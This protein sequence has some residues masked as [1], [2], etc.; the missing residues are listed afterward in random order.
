MT[1][2][3]Q[4]TAFERIRYIGE[5][6]QHS[7]D[8]MYLSR[9]IS[10]DDIHNGRHSGQFGKFMPNVALGNAECDLFDKGGRVLAQPCSQPRWSFRIHFSAPFPKLTSTC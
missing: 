1:S 6:F 3:Q 8:I 2:A 4:P 7:D 9:Y 5:F 10:G